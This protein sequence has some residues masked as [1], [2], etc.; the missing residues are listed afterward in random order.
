MNN[1][2]AYL[3]GMIMGNGEIKRSGQ[4]TT[5]SVSIPHKKLQTEDENNVHVYVAASVTNIRNVLEPLISKDLIFAQNQSESILSFTKNSGDYLIRE[6]LQFV[7]NVVSCENMRI[8]TDFYN[9]A[10]DIKNSFLRGFSD[11]TGYIRRSNYFFNKYMHRV[12][13]EVPN[14]WYM[15]VDICNLLLSIGIPVQNIDWAH[16]NMRDGNLK[17]YN[18]G[19]VNFWKKEHQIK[20]WANE[21]LPI[22][23]AVIHK[24]EALQVLASELI[25]GIKAEGK[26]VVEITHRFYWEKRACNR[27]KP[28]HPSE[29]DKFIPVDIRNKHYNSWQAIAHDLGYK[30]R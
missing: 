9:S 16:P 18:E 20:I 8:P 29:N 23:F 30:G 3:L 13:I 12:Y 28:S 1:E 6:I 7:N 4:I 26:N 11:V 14:N 25:E 21:F 5:I 17:K 15:V 27:N 19:K 10:K 24:N 2:M 22:G